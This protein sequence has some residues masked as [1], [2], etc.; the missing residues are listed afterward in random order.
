VVIAVIAGAAILFAEPYAADAA[1]T[2]NV[3]TTVDELNGDGDCSLREASR[4]A[5][6]D[7]AV[8]RCPA[9]SG[10]DTI[11]LR[12]GVYKLTVLGA[13]EQDSRAGDLDFKQSV[14]INGAGS[15]ATTIDGN[16][17]E[18]ILDVFPPASVTVND[19][20]IANGKPA[21]GRRGGGIV[22]LLDSSLTLRRT[23]VRNN[24]THD[25]PDRIPDGGGIY[26]NGRMSIINS[27]VRDNLA[28][29][30]EGSGG[31]I[32]NSGMLTITGSTISNNTSNGGDPFSF[33]IDGGGGIYN[34][35]TMTVVGST[36]SGNIS[37]YRGGGIT[38]AGTA[39][40]TTST[41][42][43]NRGQHGGA[44]FT[45]G[46]FTLGNSTVSTNFAAGDGGGIWSSAQTT[47]LWS[48]TF[49][50]NQ[51]D[52]D[53]NGF[54]DGGGVFVRAGTVF[55][56]NSLYH[57]NRDLGGEAGGC[58]VAGGAYSSQGYNRFGGTMNCVISGDQTGNIT[59]GTANIGPLANNGGPT[60]THALLAGS[61]AID[62]ANPAA[63]GS[64]FACPAVDQR[65]SARPQ[66]GNGD[67]TSRCDIGAF[68]LKP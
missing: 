6:L 66:D 41:L 56:R 31:G 28:G 47:R 37:N 67:A 63:T 26:N 36:V 49:T 48:N 46:T 18:R 52:N 44:I 64:G 10:S 38:N 23:V 15:G 54:G 58:R 50:L 19:L 45:S 11:V 5:N 32:W 42:N 21:G 55:T 68:E 16:G 60:R 57:N 24:Q 29:G 3:T 13:R 39:T 33:K 43:N 25:G 62:A 14:T 40:V 8:D 65:G 59:G 27:V 22:V 4:A 17:T 7:V 9:G 35:G 12:A 51:A 20:T 1:T 30:N 61:V 2:I 53:A 34:V